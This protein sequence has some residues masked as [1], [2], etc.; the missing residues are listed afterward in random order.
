MVKTQI[1]FDKLELIYIAAALEMAFVMNYF[2]KPVSDDNMAVL[3]IDEAQLQ[4]VS[5]MISGLSALYGEP[6][7]VLFGKQFFETCSPIVAKLLD[8]LEK[9]ND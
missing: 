9:N 3:E 5:T 2:A 1:E 6:V 7:D 4:R 8:T